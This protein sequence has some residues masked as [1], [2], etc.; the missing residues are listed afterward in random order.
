M[1]GKFSAQALKYS[2]LFQSYGYIHF[3]IINLRPTFKGTSLHR[4]KAVLTK[5]C[6][7]IAMPLLECSICEI[8]RQIDCRRMMEG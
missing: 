4:K 3:R 2:S 7:I 5:F 1:S 8:G 6:V